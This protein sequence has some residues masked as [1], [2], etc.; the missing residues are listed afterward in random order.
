MKK[1]IANYVK[2]STEYEKSWDAY[3]TGVGYQYVEPNTNYPCKSHPKD[4][5][6]NPE[7]GRT[8][9]CYAV[10]YITHGQGIFIS[11]DTGKKEISQ[12][13]FIIITPNHWHTYYPDPK[14]GWDE[15]WAT[16]NGD[17][18]TKI[19]DSICGQKCEIMEIGLSDDIVKMFLQMQQCTR[20][21]ESYSPQQLTCGI[22]FHLIGSV[23]S[24]K[25]GPRKDFDRHEDKVKEACILIRE[26]IFDNLTPEDIASR[27]NMSYSSFRKIFKK[28][29]KITPHQY[30]INLKLEKTKGLISE[31]D[32]Q[33]QEIAFKLGFESADY[34]SSFFKKWTGYTPM[35]YRKSIKSRCIS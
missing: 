13:D 10:L 20:D 9:N 8:L 14:T 19:M 31:T 29:T 11:E 21:E 2:K 32:M 4:F 12:G 16:F 15:Y 35:E 34:F 18:F 30:I 26:T 7:I 17:M 6:F 25:V 33:V 27:L 23:Y 3:V 28:Q 1:S 22:L 5:Y 24:E